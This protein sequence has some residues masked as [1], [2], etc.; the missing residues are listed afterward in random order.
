MH[1]FQSA[2]FGLVNYKMCLHF[3][4]SPSGLKLSVLLP[5]RFSHPALFIP[6]KD[7]QV[8][9]QESWLFPLVNLKF[10]QCPNVSVKISRG[11]GEQLEESSGGQFHIPSA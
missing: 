9:S 6:W 3:G 11:L 10:L 5:F 4:S 8:E 7:V 1:S 2:R